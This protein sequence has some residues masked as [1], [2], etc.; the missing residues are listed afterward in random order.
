MVKTYYG[1]QT[2]NSKWQKGVKKFVKKMKLKVD[3]WC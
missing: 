2:S 1:N 3:E